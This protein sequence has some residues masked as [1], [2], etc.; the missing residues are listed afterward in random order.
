M[1]AIK[2]KQSTAGCR[3]AA[4]TP[5]MG[6]QEGQL[7]S[8]PSSMVAGGARIA[9]YTELFSSLLSYEGASSGVED[10]LIQENVSRSKLPDLHL[11][12]VL[13]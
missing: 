1:A 12:I 10:S 8:L 3:A 7:S 5:I 6:R 9:L 4:G 13:L 2:L 11:H